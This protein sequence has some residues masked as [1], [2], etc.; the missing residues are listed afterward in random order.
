M[1]LQRGPAASVTPVKWTANISKS[2]STAYHQNA[3][4]VNPLKKHVAADFPRQTTKPCPRHVRRSRRR[5]GGFRE[6]SK[7]WRQRRSRCWT[8][9]H[10]SRSEPFFFLLFLPPPIQA[11]W[12]VWSTEAEPGEQRGVLIDAVTFLLPLFVCVCV[13]GGVA[14]LTPGADVDMRQEHVEMRFVA[15]CRN[16]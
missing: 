4:S 2:V 3:I 6:T 1:W 16:V 14:T 12:L 11:A 10:K 15:A 13:G 9:P 7:K 5:W 8:R